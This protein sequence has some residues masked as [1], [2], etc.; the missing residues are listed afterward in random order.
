MLLLTCKECQTDYN[1]NKDK[2]GV[3]DVRLFHPGDWR[4]S[5]T[6]PSAFYAYLYFYLHNKCSIKRLHMITINNQS[7]VIKS[8]IPP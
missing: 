7:L 8:C 6:T 4:Y 2:K 3:Y 1:N 5:N